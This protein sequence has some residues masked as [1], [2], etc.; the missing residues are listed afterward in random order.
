MGNF[1][2][3]IASTGT[4]TWKEVKKVKKIIN[5]SKLIL[6][7]CV[8]AYPANTNNINLP[9][10]FEL[11]KINNKVGYSGHLPGVFDAIA[12]LNY[13]PEFIEKHF[14]IDNKLPGRDNKFALMPAELKY[15]VNYKNSLS[16]MNTFRG[17]N[18]Q[19]VEIDMR[20]N[21]RGRWSKKL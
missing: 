19:N 16:H 1:D 17:K 13:H 4:A 2:Y 8:S 15:L 10:I 9:R 20:T 14:T 5:K 12:S 11:K 3:V 7:H 21:Y 18:F 6:L